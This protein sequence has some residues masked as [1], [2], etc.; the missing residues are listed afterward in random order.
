VNAFS[1]W[2]SGLETVRFGSLKLRYRRQ[3]DG[4]PVLL[5]HGW[6]T[7]SFLWRKVMIP[8]ARS[9]T[10]VALDLPGFGQS[11]KPQGVRYDFEFFDAAVDCLADELGVDALALAGHD[12][13][14]PIAV[15][16]AIEHPKRVTKLALLNTVIY[17]EFC[18]EVERFF[19][20]CATTGLRERLTSRDGLERALRLG[21]ANESRLSEEARAAVLAPFTTD[22]ARRALADAGCGVTRADFAELARRLPALSA[23]VTLLYG[24]RD[25]IL[26]DVAHT[27]NRLQNDLPCAEL[28]SLNDCGHFLQEEAPAR[29]GKLLARFFAG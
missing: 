7:S 9:Q 14:G 28:T 5:L 20:A 18:E 19:R 13:G 22:D 8:L 2:A 17:P 24:A 21:L 12:L 11:D 16:W 4:P 26:P 29:I 1:E 27:M 3:G 23:P 10:V 6:P 25:R 15:H